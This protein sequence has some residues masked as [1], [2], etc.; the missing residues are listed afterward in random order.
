MAETARQT[1]QDIVARA[2]QHAA[3]SLPA[4]ERAELGAV[5][6]RFGEARVVELGEATHGTSGFHR[7]RAA[8]TRPLIR[9]HE[10]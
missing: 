9:N 10:A 2:V 7:A 5:F 8:I 4:P 3:E 6:A 1:T